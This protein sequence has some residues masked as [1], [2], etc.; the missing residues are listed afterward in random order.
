MTTRGKLRRK[1]DTTNPDAASCPTEAVLQWA[2]AEACAMLRCGEDPNTVSQ[3]ELQRRFYRDLKQNK[4]NLMVYVDPRC[5]VAKMDKLGQF[6]KPDGK[7]AFVLEYKGGGEADKIGPFAFEAATTVDLD[8]VD[9]L[10][11]YWR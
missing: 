7:I 9:V 4:P 11:V 1:S 10:S 2:W 5:R 6:T 3:D 8:G